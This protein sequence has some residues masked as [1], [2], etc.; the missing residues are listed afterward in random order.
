M[1]ELQIFKSPEF[2]QVRTVT[3][4]GGPWFVGKDV[5]DILG[6]QNG[7]RDINRHV[8]DEDKTSVVIPDTGS[9]YKSRATLINEFCSIFHVDA[10]QAVKSHA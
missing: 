1:N 3:I 2:G 7:S 8:D 9:N 5:A 4:D 6:Y 10:E